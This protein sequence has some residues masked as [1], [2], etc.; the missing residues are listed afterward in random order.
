ME[1]LLGN[2]SNRVA[3][4]TGASR[5]IGAEITRELATAGAFG[6][7]RDLFCV[8]G[9]PVDDRRNTVRDRHPCRSTDLLGEV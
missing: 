1:E 9:C 7:R 8:R 2:L 3:M 6:R 5:G 4:V